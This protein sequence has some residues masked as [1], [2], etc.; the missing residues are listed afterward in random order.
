MPICKQCR[1]QHGAYVASYTTKNILY[2]WHQK[3]MGQSKVWDNIEKV[4]L[5]LCTICRIKENNKFPLLFEFPFYIIIRAV[6]A[7]SI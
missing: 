3:L 4:Y 5:F 6:I 7:Q 2:R 1:G